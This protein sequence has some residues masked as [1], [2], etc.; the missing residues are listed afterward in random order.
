MSTSGG[1]RRWGI[2]AGGGTAAFALEGLRARRSLSLSER[3]CPCSVLAGQAAE[4]AAA[5][6]GGVYVDV[7][8]L[9]VGADTDAARVC[10]Q[11]VAQGQGGR[12]SAFLGR[13]V[14]GP[15]LAQDAFVG[16]Y[17][18]AYGGLVQHLGD[19]LGF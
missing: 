13:V 11:V 17:L 8:A 6:R 2:C 5:G 19:F 18:W 4:A 14:H 9:V 7:G 16:R 10:G 1:C 3:C 15:R 12:G